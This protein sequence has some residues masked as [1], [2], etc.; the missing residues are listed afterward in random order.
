MVVHRIVVV[1]IL[2]LA[3]VQA[4]SQNSPAEP[5]WSKAE[6]VTVQLSN[7][8]F[9]PSTITL[10]QGQT[11]A[12]RVVNMAKGGHD[13]AAK[14][15]FSAARIMDSDRAKVSDG[16]IS[17]QGG[18]S[19]AVHFIMPHSGTYKLRCTHFMHSS[20]GMA[21]EIVVQ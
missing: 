1:G 20:F 19:I 18:Q 11:Y 6:V 8:R 3:P 16:K 4:A 10:K 7:F 13:F 5:N 12:L 2:M 21:G 9:T 15:F 17:L 14:E